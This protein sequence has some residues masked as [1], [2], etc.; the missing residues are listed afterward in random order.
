MSILPCTRREGALLKMVMR[1]G[2]EHCPHGV[3][4]HEATHLRLTK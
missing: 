3:R 4:H 1:S 2:Y